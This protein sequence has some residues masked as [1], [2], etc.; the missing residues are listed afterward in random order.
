[1]VNL[2]RCL[3]KLWVTLKVFIELD[4][5]RKAFIGKRNEIERYMKIETSGKNYI[6]LISKV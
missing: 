3:S 6:M 4:V 2:A 1:M 5:A